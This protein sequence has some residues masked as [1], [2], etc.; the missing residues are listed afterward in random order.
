ML[1]IELLSV[2]LLIVIRDVTGI[3]KWHTA[4]D[5]QT[6]LIDEEQKVSWKSKT[7]R[8]NTL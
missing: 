3:T 7:R 5:G 4:S 6:F 8:K 2:G 1:K